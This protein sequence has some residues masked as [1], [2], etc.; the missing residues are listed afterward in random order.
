MNI[1]YPASFWA[2]VMQFS[3]LSWFVLWSSVF[4]DVGTQKPNDYVKKTLTKSICKHIF[5]LKLDKLH[6]NILTYICDRWI[7]RM[8]NKKKIVELCVHI[9]LNEN[10]HAYLSSRIGKDNFLCTSIHEIEKVDFL[11]FWKGQAIWTTVLFLF[12]RNLFLK[13]CFHIYIF[14]LAC[15]KLDAL[16]NT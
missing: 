16:D 2:Y 4:D 7:Q 12:S 6:T 10:S 13:W 1:K 14:F 9:F 5:L 11:F 8:M 15:L 3:R